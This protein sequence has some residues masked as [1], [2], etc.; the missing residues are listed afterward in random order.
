MEIPDELVYKLITAES[1]NNPNAVSRAGARGYAQFMPATAKQYGVDP[2]DFQSSFSGAKRYLSDLAGQ[3]GGDL[4]TALQAFNWGP[5]NMQAY[6]KTGAGMKGQPM[7][8]ETQAYVSRVLRAKPA[9]APVADLGDALGYS[10]GGGGA[11]GPAGGESLDLGAALGYNKTDARMRDAIERR[12]I[13]GK[14]IDM[15]TQPEMDNPLLAMGKDLLRQG[16]LTARAGIGAAGD[17]IG[18]GSEPI[19]MG[20]EAMGLPKMASASQLA[21]SLSNTV[22]LPTPQNGIERI[23]QSG[24]RTM[25]GVSGIA[26]AA[27]AATRGLSGTAANV[28]SALAQQPAQQAIAG[29]TGGVSGGYAK[30]SGAGPV[31]QMTASLAGALGGAAGTAGVQRLGSAIN[32]GIEALSRRLS[33]GNWTNEVNVTLNGILQDNGINLSQLPVT[34]RT[35]LADEM[36]AALNTGKNIDPKVVQRIAD[37]GMV[38]ATPTRGS[39]TLNP[40]QITQERNLAKVGANS[41][42]TAL[43]ELA[44]V[45]NRNNAAIIRNMDEFGAA[46]PFAENRLAAG[47]SVIND[48]RAQDSQRAAEATR[49]Y[50]AA[51][52]AS[53]R[54]IELDRNGFVDAV[55][56]NLADSGNGAFLPAEIQ[57]LLRG[58]RTGTMRVGRE[59]I[60]VPFN[61]GVIDNLE[62]KL[63]TAMRSS[64]DS[65][66]KK[67]IYDVRKALS[68]VEPSAVGMPVG[69]N[70]V[71]DPVVLNALQGEADA[72]AASALDAFRAARSIHRARMQW[73]ESTPSIKAALGNDVAGE[74]F[75]KN[76]FLSSADKSGAQR[77][78]E[79]AA[80]V[81]NNP[82]ATQAIRQSVA[83]WLKDRATGGGADE[84]SVF[85][86][87]N[88]NKAL[89]ELGDEKL[90]IVFT[91]EEI[92][93]LRAIG[94]VASYEQ[95]QP[96]GSAV[97]NSN[98]AG[99]AAG[100]IDRIAS[101]PIV[102]RIPFAR[103]AIQDPAR[104]WSAQIAS[105]RAMTPLSALANPV[106]R[107]PSPGIPLGALLAIPA[108]EQSR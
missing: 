49:L 69:G 46:G 90:R 97:N 92:S 53:G 70:R 102:G 34:V 54:Y 88:Y 94:R 24:A 56:K 81:S 36:K 6:L 75:I 10:S 89:R 100:L 41:R 4:R 64:T 95:F 98:T 29:A 67:A 38:G 45:R 52:D 13:S 107:P 47:S 3:F 16:G 48:I 78:A 57:S 79:L 83:R 87:S 40:V 86:Q 96:A 61:V 103:A 9:V 80:L 99:A 106:V 43:Q 63:A 55:N 72:T 17:I 59:K 66:A 12:A 8:A 35:Q 37:Y 77:S 11:G 15:P 84:V 85:S 25:G 19:R 93:R 18:M 44:M 31:G 104:Q 50:N 32:A 76:F 1:N 68:N 5:G 62:T 22:G 105:R 101:N 74:N 2:A 7:P 33:P 30:E 60:D 71:V 28:A 82:N 21:D 73:Q 65:N 42:D 26:G 39:V 51:R 91:P 58:I 20:L 14:A 27:G 23:A 108:L